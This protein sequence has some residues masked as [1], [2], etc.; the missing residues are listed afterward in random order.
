MK[1]ALHRSIT[2]WS[3]LFVLLPIILGWQDSMTY[4]SSA[5]IG[6][7]RGVFLGNGYAGIV[8]GYG[9]TASGHAEARRER[10]DSGGEKVDFSATPA[11][12]FWGEGSVPEHRVAELMQRPD[13]WVVPVYSLGENF[14]LWT[15]SVS[16]IYIP[17]WLILLTVAL[18][19]S[20][21][22]YWR[23]RRR[24]RTITP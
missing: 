18:P 8:I 19:W 11:P 17:H 13:V 3:G 16:F 22:P 23:S 5:S 24:K 20:I 10:L 21:L 12:G 1:L 14:E 4:M 15:T 6:S 2:F 9:W 7:S